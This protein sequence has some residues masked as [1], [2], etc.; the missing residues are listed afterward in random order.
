MGVYLFGKDAKLYLADVDMI[1]TDPPVAGYVWTEYKNITDVV[2]NFAGVS[3]DTTT[4]ETAS[5]G[6]TSAETILNTGEVSLT[7]PQKVNIDIVLRVFIDAW[8]TKTTIPLAVL[9]GDKDTV[10]NE[11]LTAN[12]S[13]EL[14]QNQPLQDRQTWDAVLRVASF[15]VWWRTT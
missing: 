7:I 3:V 12:F 11:G 2:G 1:G 9:S 14:T 15:P 10:G 13:V 5:T 8:L 4:R 6:W